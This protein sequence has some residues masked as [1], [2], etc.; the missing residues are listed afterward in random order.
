MVSSLAL[1][2]KTIEKLIAKGHYEKA[3]E[4]I[5]KLIDAHSEVEVIYKSLT[6]LN[7]ICDKTPSIALKVVK[8]VSNY[9]NETDSWIRLE[10]LE[11][12]YQISMYR[13]NLLIELIDKIKGRYYDQEAVVRRLAVKIVGNLILSLHIDK[14]ALQN[15]IEEFTEK[16]MDNDW[17]VKLNVIKTLQDILNQDYTKVKDLEPLLSIAI[18]NLRDEDDDVARSAAELL[19]IL[20]TYFLSKDKIFYMLLNLLYNEKSRVK[21]L[22]IWLFGEIGKEKSSEVI[23]IIPKLIKLLEE[24]NYRIQIKVIDA[25]VNIAENNFDQIW[26]NLIHG[27]L[28]TSDKDHRSNLIHALYHLSQNKISIIFDYIFEELENPSENI[29]D[30][31]ALV[32]KRVFE[33]HQVEIE[34]E[35]TKILYKLESKYWRERQK[36]ISLLQN[37]CFILSDEKITVWIAIELDKALAREN[38]A[39]VKQDIINFLNRIKKSFKNIDIKIKEIEQQLELINEEILKFQKTPAEFREELNSNIREFKFNSTEIQLNK[40]Y[41]QII[42]KINA[43]HKEID[44]FD[45]KRLAFDLI[46][47]WE[48]TKI[49]IIE[50]LGIIKSFISEICSERKEEFLQELNQKIKLLNDRIGILDVKFEYI[51]E[52]DFQANIE[53]I[54][55]NNIVDEDFEDKFSYITQIRKDLFNLDGDIRELMINN[56]EFT[57]VFKQL[58]R[59]WVATKVKLQEFLS[60]LDRNLKNIKEGTQLSN[61]TGSEDRDRDVPKLK[62]EVKNKFAYQ[63]LQGHIQELISQ[64]VDG[65]NK[66]NEN[67]ENLES[68]IDFEIKKK[69]FK[70]GEHLIEVNSSQIQT[71]IEDIE[72]QIEDISGKEKLLKDNNLFDLYMRPYLEKWKYSKEMLINKLGDFEKKNQDKIIIGKISYYLEVMNPITLDI[73]SSYL[74]IDLKE[75]NSKI[76]GFINNNQLNAKIINNSLISLQIESKLKTNDLLFFKDVKTIGN[77]IYLQFKLSNPTSFSF[78]DIQISLKNPSYLKFLRK[79]SFPRILYLNELKQSKN[80]KFN[81]VFKIGKDITRD[82]NAPDADEIKLNIYYKDHFNISRKTSKRLN[83]LLT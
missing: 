58:L 30:G 21:E 35:I 69:E 53:K 60:D 70:K 77:K 43:F 37:V 72:R 20:S 81:Y 63:I 57:D 5:F 27:L 48:E 39:D 22:I 19:K 32:F 50:E 71:Y 62:E 24:D 64:G 15:L 26:A 8:S 67:F 17:K 55:S 31:I 83:L 25:L 13:P 59:K 75:L 16:L 42:K 3:S 40:R 74:E 11:I 68:K 12:F 44:K 56:L 47:E 46:E 54:L 18:L 6:L 14:S 51:K 33:E 61:S 7:Q 66:I 76:L 1:N 80:F 45:Y 29:R 82:I 78:K 34:N 41:N 73:L 49:Q 9:I 2:T 38:D 10:I 65:F 4:D 79:E 52:Y 36:T 28:E 23:P